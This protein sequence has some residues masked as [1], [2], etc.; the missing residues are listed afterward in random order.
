MAR[1]LLVSY[2]GYP[3][4]LS[5]LF[6][7]NGLASLAAVLR[8]EG[9]ECQVLDFNTP[10]VMGR[11]LGQSERDTLTALLPQLSDATPELLSR[12]QAV[13][14]SIDRRS[15][16][17]ADQLAAELVDRSRKQRC[18]FVGFKLWS[19]EGFVASLR[20][21]GQLRT[22]L[23]RLHLFAGGPA[24]HY[25][26]EWT[27]SEA[28]VFDALIDGDGE[29]AILDLAAFVEDKR[30]R[31]DI[32][33]LVRKGAPREP[34][35][36]RGLQDLD[37][38]P[39][40][41]YGADAYPAVASGEKLKLFCIDESRGCPMR[42]PFCI[43]W[44]IQGSR[45]RTRSPER[46]LALVLDN[47]CRHRSRAFRLSGT[48][49]PPGLVRR[50]C[51][52]ISESRARV[53]FGL[54]LHAKGMNED[55]VGLLKQAGCAGVF[56]GAESGSDEILSH[57]MGKHVGSAR[58][59]QVIRLCQTA[60]LYTAASFIVPA[61]GET[62]QSATQTR[63]MI[64]TLFSGQEHGS[65]LVNLPGLLPRTT[66]WEH[67]S[68]YGFKLEVSEEEYCRLLLRYKIRHII[69]PLLWE[70]LPYSLDGR[71]YLEMVAATSALQGWLKAQGIVVNLADHDALVGAALGWTPA[72]TAQRVR[73]AIFCGDAAELQGLVT[74]ANRAFSP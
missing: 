64:R 13:S 51:Q 1:G 57:V 17:V 19:G 9:H 29:Q 46:V 37:Q 70:P 6:P 62:E 18:D 15:Q 36:D 65:V 12:L 7:D 55:L 68:R 35:H 66:W 71:G 5:S 47:L 69:P 50:L 2:A 53:S 38:L 59:A 49:T 52:L 10:E 32:H 31:D 73:Q 21:A 28:P 61:P 58:I 63:E 74:A 23:P 16:Q 44:R 42:C 3:Y 40:P 39:P 60:G 22:A 34:G 4:A 25:S 45:W 27:A 48:Y 67:R 26:G 8:S 11:L 43:N 54:Y 24:V 14:A 33:N 41:D 56:V 30:R 20:M 72:E